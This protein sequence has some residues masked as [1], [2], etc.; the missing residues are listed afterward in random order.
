ML[1]ATNRKVPFISSTNKSARSLRLRFYWAQW[2]VVAVQCDHKRTNNSTLSEY[3][4]LCELLTRTLVDKVDYFDE[5]NVVIFIPAVWEV[6]KCTS[7]VYKQLL[8]QKLLSEPEVLLRVIVSLYLGG[9]DHKQQLL[10]AKIIL[11]NALLLTSWSMWISQNEH[12]VWFVC[13]L[14]YNLKFI[15]LQ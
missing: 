12:V 2:Q 7:L 9:K 4:H 6:Q 10:D 8:L 15:F 3:M 11:F 13:N 1:P 5:G 14:K